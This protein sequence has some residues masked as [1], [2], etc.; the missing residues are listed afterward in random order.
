MPGVTV[1]DEVGRLIL[2]GYHLIN[3][4][5]NHALL[6]A[7]RQRSAGEVTLLVIGLLLGVVGIYMGLSSAQTWT[8]AVGG[9][10]IAVTI[11]LYVI[12][13]RPSGI[14]VF[15]DAAGEVRHE[16]VRGSHW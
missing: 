11:A 8:L 13:R 7:P 3:R 9:G 10:V 5:D 2:R 16:R 12:K 6:A 1:E 14:R 4:G 15:L